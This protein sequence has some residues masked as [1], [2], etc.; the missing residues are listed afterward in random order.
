MKSEEKKERKKIIPSLLSILVTLA[1]PLTHN[2]GF[3][4]D[5]DGA[6]H[7]FAGTSLAE[8]GTEG[9]VATWRGLVAGYLAIRLDAVL[10][11]V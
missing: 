7:V 4:V 9:V 5:E 10:Q 8:E 3:Q 1:H 2:C 11:A 6:G